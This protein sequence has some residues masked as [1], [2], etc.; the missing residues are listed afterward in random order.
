MNNKLEGLTIIMEGLMKQYSERVPDVEKIIKGML[1]KSII[2]NRSDIE[3]DHIAF[4]TI[5]VPLLG[6]QSLEKIFCHYGYE[7]K[8]ISGSKAKSL[9]P[10][11]FHH[12][13]R[14]F[15]ESLSA[16]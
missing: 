16:N 6:I 3:N 13:H 11:G 1:D 14:S 15:P 5:G 2:Q 9:M 10:T 4:R 8:I 12:L 7:K